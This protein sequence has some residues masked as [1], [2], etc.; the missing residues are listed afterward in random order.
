VRGLNA[1][2]PYG[3]NRH[4]D[5]LAGNKIFA[6]KFTKANEILISFVMACRFSFEI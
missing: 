6:L 3:V 2:V 4:F 1:N 5:L